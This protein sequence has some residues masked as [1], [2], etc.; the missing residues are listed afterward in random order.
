[1][2]DGAGSFLLGINDS[3]DGGDVS[4]WVDVSSDIDCGTCDSG[5]G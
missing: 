5:W 3:D 1:M 2:I 4:L